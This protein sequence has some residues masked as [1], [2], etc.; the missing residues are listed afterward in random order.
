MPGSQSRGAL[1]WLHYSSNEGNRRQGKGNPE[2]KMRFPCPPVRAGATQR[3]RLIIQKGPRAHLVRVQTLVSRPTCLD[4][5]GRGC[6]EHCNPDCAGQGLQPT[7]IPEL[8]FERIVAQ[9]SAVAPCS[10]LDLHWAIH[11]PLFLSLI[12]QP[13][14][15]AHKPRLGASTDQLLP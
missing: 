6:G 9:A 8:S 1:R 12:P 3:H 4:S 7:A 15:P 13:P 10:L 2:A 14:P 11:S 5:H